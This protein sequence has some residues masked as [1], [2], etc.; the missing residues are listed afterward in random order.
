MSKNK[1]L[2]TDLPVLRQT[3]ADKKSELIGDKPSTTKFQHLLSISLIL[4]ISIA[5]YSN[6]LKNGFVYDDRFTIVDNLF[7][8]NWNNLPELFSKTYFS[9]SGEETYRPIVT[10]SYFVDYSLWGL[11]P[12]GYHLTNLLL[13]SANVV[14]VYLFALLLLNNPLSPTLLRGS[15]ITHTHTY[16]R[17]IA[18]FTALLFSIHPIQSEAV[19]AI[20]FREDLL[21]VFFLTAAFILYIKLKEESEAEGSKLKAQ[22]VCFQLLAFSF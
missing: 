7:I 2:K 9:R 12:F 19:N 8:K 13:H 16:T 20:S 4:I 22:R 14:L 21:V 17:W 11:K 18:F 3:G 15:N 1:K 5:I 6:T 10:L